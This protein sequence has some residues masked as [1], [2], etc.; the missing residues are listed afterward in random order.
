[1]NT[2]LCMCH[3]GDFAHIF[4]QVTWL[5]WS[6]PGLKEEELSR[7]AKCNAGSHP[8]SEGCVDHQPGLFFALEISRH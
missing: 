2:L 4:T 8:V 7:L 6:T 3:F 5:T 1:M